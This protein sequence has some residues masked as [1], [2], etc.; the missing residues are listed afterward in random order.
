METAVQRDYIYHDTFIPLYSS[1]EFRVGTKKLSLDST[2]LRNR[3]AIELVF[4]NNGVQL[5][6]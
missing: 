3:Q 4:S 6:H 2:A 1:R 5:K